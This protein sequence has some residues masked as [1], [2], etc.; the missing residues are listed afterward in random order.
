[1]LFRSVFESEMNYPEDRPVLPSISRIFDHGSTRKPSSL[2]LPPLP[3]P[4]QCSTQHSFNQKIH[5]ETWPQFPLP[6]YDY[7]SKA[8]EPSPSSSYAPVPY[9]PSDQSVPSP[10]SSTHS[11]SPRELHENFYYNHEPYAAPTSTLT[12]N[13]IRFGYENARSYDDL[14]VQ[15][16]YYPRS[17]HIVS[18][19]APQFRHHSSS[20]ILYN[21]HSHATGTG[22]SNARHQCTYCSKRFSRPSGLKIH[23]TTH[24]GE[25]PFTCPEPGCH[26]SFSVRSNMR[27]HVRI[28]HQSPESSR[29]NSESGDDGDVDSRDPEEL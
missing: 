9:A 22:S 27:R 14:Y 4:S 19:P 5:S 17:Y 21:Y 11:L 7:Y 25:K 1:M 2:T 20:P 28:V 12:P 26:R 24:T 18:R 8:C 13:S 29:T 6:S 15:P 23:L 10:C 16:S 3:H